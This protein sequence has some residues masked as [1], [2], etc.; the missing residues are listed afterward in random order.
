MDFLYVR[1]TSF[2]INIAQAFFPLL[3][4]P[5]NERDNFQTTLW[6]EL[7][8]SL[9]HKSFVKFKSG[10]ETKTIWINKFI[11]FL[12]NCFSYKTVDDAL[13]CD[14]RK[15]EK[16][17]ERPF[18]SWAW[19]MQFR[20]RK[21]FSTH[22]VVLLGIFPPH[23][24]WNQQKMKH[25]EENNQNHYQKKLLWALSVIINQSVNKQ[26]SSESDVLKCYLL[27]YFIF[28]HSTLV[29]VKYFDKCLSKNKIKY[30]WSL[31]ICQVKF[32]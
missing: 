22:N 20:L 7:H 27:R 6:V 32:F 11:L 1:F 28:C 18:H 24:L 4:F 2:Q 17:R 29:E 8:S 16:S 10:I 21:R 23:K 13:R 12:H 31:S 9:E 5:H 3:L 26:L 19:K 15:A 14:A 30:V 25:R